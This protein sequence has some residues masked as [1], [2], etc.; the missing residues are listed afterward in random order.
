MKSFKQKAGAAP[1]LVAALR[2]R[3][4]EAQNAWPSQGAKYSS[5]LQQL[6][7]G[8]LKIRID[9]LAKRIG[10]P[11]NKENQRLFG[12]L[13]AAK[14]EVEKLSE[15][16]W[17]ARMPRK[18]REEH[19]KT[20][21]RKL[22]KGWA[23]RA[24]GRSRPTYDWLAKYHTAA[25]FR[26]AT[27]R[28]DSAVRLLLK[29]KKPLAEKQPGQAYQYSRAVALRVLSHWLSK[30]AKAKAKEEAC[31]IWSCRSAVN[32]DSHDVLLSVLKPF[33]PE[34]GVPPKPGLLHGL[35]AYLDEAQYNPCAS[36]VDYPWWLRGFS[37]S[38]V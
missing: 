4:K 3:P 17:K 24:E 18:E 1:L 37:D 32:R 23:R 27:G 6:P 28:C 12:Y 11:V 8:N 29:G 22:V 15:E 33:A 20:A 10:L 26:K 38:S 2:L 13:L 9:Q 34:V 31:A 36:E 25:S 35:Q 30:M 19:N 14:E 21:R 16:L 7:S 5:E